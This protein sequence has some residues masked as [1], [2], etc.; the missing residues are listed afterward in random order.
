M[1][2]PCPKLNI[3]PKISTQSFFLLPSDDLL[4]RRVREDH[5]KAQSFLSGVCLIEY[6]FSLQVP[7][8]TPLVSPKQTPHL[9]GGGRQ[10]RPSQ[11]A[12]AITSGGTRRVQN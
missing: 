9:S 3:F 1:G 11:K 7:S 6:V 2:A 4:S 8:I 5:A 10:E 12:K